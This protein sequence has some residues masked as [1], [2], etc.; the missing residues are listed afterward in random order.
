[1]DRLKIRVGSKKIGD[2]IAGKKIT[3]FG[4]IWQVPVTDEHACCYGMESGLDHYPSISYHY[5]YLS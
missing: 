4:K 5:A 3:G 2:E 1:M